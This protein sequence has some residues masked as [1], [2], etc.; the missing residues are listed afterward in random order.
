MTADEFKAWLA[1]MKARGYNKS[2]CAELLGRKSP[3]ISVCQQK[4][5]DR[6]TALAC[7]ALVQGLEPYKK[8]R[9]A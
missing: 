5:S 3:W 9:A 6:L 1:T 2:D 4:G 7:A 8:G